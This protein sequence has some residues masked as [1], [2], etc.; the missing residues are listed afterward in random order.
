MAVRVAVLVDADNVSNGQIEFAV[1]EAAKCGV[2]TIR[3]AFGRVGSL[4]SR[5]NQLGQLGFS[6]EAALPGTGSKNTTDFLLSQ[7][8][9]Q[10]AER[11]AIDLIVIVSSDSDFATVANGIGASGVPTLCIGREESPN[12]LKNAASH[13]IAFQTPPPEIAAAPAKTAKSGQETSKKTDARGNIGKA[14]RVIRATLDTNGHAN[15]SPVGQRLNLAF[16]GDYKKVFGVATLSK[17]IATMP[18]E[19]EIEKLSNAGKTSKVVKDRR[20]KKND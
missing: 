8:A 3:R 4:Q 2:I 10:M 17:L 16:D 6:A 20:H 5:E 9:V 18:S 12:A 13:F 14:I 19:F 1:A 11:G 7:F 15:M